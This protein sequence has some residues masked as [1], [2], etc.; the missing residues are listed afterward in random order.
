MDN[1]S[2]FVVNCGAKKVDSKKVNIDGSDDMFYRYKV[3]QLLVQVVGKGKMIKTMFLN[4][5]EVAR[6]LHLMPEY[7]PAYMGYEIGAQF[8]Y[9]NKKPERERA[10][11]SGEYTTAVLSD[12][13]TKLIKEVVL[14][15]HC[16]L[17]ELKMSCETKRKAVFLTCASCGNREE[18]IKCNVKFLRFIGNNPPVNVGGVEAKKTPQSKITKKE[19]PEEKEKLSTSAEG[20]SAAN[21]EEN[22]KEEAQ[23]GPDIEFTEEEI[24]RTDAELKRAAEVGVE[25]K[26]DTSREAMESRRAE[27]VPESIKQLV[28]SGVDNSGF[29]RLKSFLEKS[30]ADDE[31]VSLLSSLRGSNSIDDD[32]AV[33]AIF[34]FIFAKGDYV[35][36]TKGHLPLLKALLKSPAS[37]IAFL[38]QLEVGLLSKGAAHV[39]KSSAFLQSFYDLDLVEEQ[40]IMKWSTS[41]T[42]DNAVRVAAKP[43]LDWLE[44]ADE[45]SEDE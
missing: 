14:C 32:E 9:E 44:T 15:K 21:D 2:F 25:W 26:S 42:D 22:E 29:N 12:V 3:N 7:I 35:K 40:S 30:P 45:E 6:G 17:P 43:F 28:V 11:I 5:D 8:K 39:K 27:L 34:P 41:P 13:L 36:E 38:L 20:E 31:V 23:H 16:K 24:S 19:E 33:D 18:L 4:N 1:K 10:H 37:Q